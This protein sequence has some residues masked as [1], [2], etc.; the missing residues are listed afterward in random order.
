[1]H[2]FSFLRSAP[3]KRDFSKENLSKSKEFL[4]PFNFLLCVQILLKISGIV[5]NFNLNICKW[6]FFIVDER[7]Q[8]TLSL[9]DL[10]ADKSWGGIFWPYF[11][12]FMCPPYNVEKKIA[13][14]LNIGF[15]IAI[16]VRLMKIQKIFKTIF[17][18]T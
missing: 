10:W 14:I 17:F 18:Q 7:P 11:D 6:V 13:N 9:G 2:T 12:H 15:V 16:F 8:S 4:D 3:L 1:M 5:K